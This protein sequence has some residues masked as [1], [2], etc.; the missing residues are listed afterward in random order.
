MHSSSFCLGA[1]QLAQ[2]HWQVFSGF[3]LKQTWAANAIYDVHV[4]WTLITYPASTKND[5]VGSDSSV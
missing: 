1:C 4:S 3:Q 2:T 5:D